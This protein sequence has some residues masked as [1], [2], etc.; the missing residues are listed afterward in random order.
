MASRGEMVQCFPTQISLQLASFLVLPVCLLFTLADNRLN[1][2]S[3]PISPERPIEV[4]PLCRVVLGVTAYPKLM[5]HYRIIIWMH[6][7][8]LSRKPILLRHVWSFHVAWE[9]FGQHSRW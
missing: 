6:M 4:S 3:I 8:A 1:L 9:P 7:Y 5:T 2:Y